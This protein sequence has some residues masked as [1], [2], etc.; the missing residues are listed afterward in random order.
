MLH[1][2]AVAVFFYGTFTKQLN[3]LFGQNVDFY[4]RSG[5]I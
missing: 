3:T 1:S 5:G 2:E 4:V